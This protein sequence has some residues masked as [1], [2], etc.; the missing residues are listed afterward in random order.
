MEDRW[1][2]F[3][4]YPHAEVEGA[5]AGP[6]RG[7]RLAVKDLFD[8]AGY[9]TAAGNAVLLSASGVK[10][11][12]APLVTTLLNAG[13]RFVGKT[14][15]DELAY[16]LTGDNIHFG[17]PVNPSNPE[18]ISGGS[19]SGSAVA[20]AAQLADVGLGTDTS[21]S[22][23][24]PA[25]VNGLIGW[26][27]THGSLNTDGLRPLAPSFDVPGFI[28]A[29]M[30]PLKAIMDALGLK[31]REAQ[32]SSIL[33]AE[34]MLDSID[35]VIAKSI[36]RSVESTGLRVEMVRA[37]ATIIP[38]DLTTAF[39]TILQREAWECNRAFFEQHGE[40]VAPGIATRLLAGSR[41]DAVDVREA[42]GLRNAFR[43][44]TAHLLAFGNVVA[45][46]TL[47]MEAPLRDAGADQL[48]AF[49]GR[50]IRLLCLAGLGGYPQ[51]AFPASAGG[52]EFSLSLLGAPNADRMLVDTAGRVRQLQ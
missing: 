51:L 40:T 41:L 9:P 33:I 26:R 7:L 38:D 1:N 5:D 20:V 23:R 11:Q 17:M 12:T 4:P 8:V 2:A 27:P 22:I 29:R 35:P 24:L 32:A 13:A 48:M 37:F 44:E 28:T 36:V 39:V 14:N 43:N 47:P 21:G 25:A 34:D 52:R 30:E 16:S 31:G 6:L 45:L 15:T 3:V 50:C 19:S 49:R 46:P 18:K 10:T 42:Y